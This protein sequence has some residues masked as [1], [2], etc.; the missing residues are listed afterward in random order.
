VRLEYR[1]GTSSKFWEI[2]V[3]RGAYTVT[4]GRIG[5]KGQ[6]KTTRSSNAA[7]D[8]EKL[9]AAKRKKGYKLVGGKPPVASAPA[10][11]VGKPIAASVIRKL[12]T[13][14]DRV[15]RDYI[16]SEDDDPDDKKRYQLYPRASEREIAAHEKQLGRKLPPSYRHFLRMHNGW[17]G[18]WGDSALLGVPKPYNA[19][20]W[21]YIK[22]DLRDSD[23]YLDE[24]DEGPDYFHAADVIPISCDLNGGFVAFDMTRIN[25]RGEPSIIDC[26]RTNGCVDNR[27]DDFVAFLELRISCAKK[28]IQ[29]NKQKR[30]A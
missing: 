6:R 28:W 1:K 30:R 21:R 9:A 17:L 5:S 22:R 4:F 10:K 19:P 18:Y 13:Q 14:L 15:T 7:S 25:K 11:P 26:M 8:A 24:D 20:Y 3:A 12:V 16:V 2:A 29:R 23:G 27:F